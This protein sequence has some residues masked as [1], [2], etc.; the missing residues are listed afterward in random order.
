MESQQ[1]IQNEKKITPDEVIQALRFYNL[2]SETKL[3]LEGYKKCPVTRE[4]VEKAY[5]D[6][7]AINRGCKFKEACNIYLSFKNEANRS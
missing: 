2:E 5:C 3:I 7:F 6:S 4:Y 1:T